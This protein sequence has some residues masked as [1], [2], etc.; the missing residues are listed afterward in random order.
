MKLLR[1]LATAFAISFVLGFTW[2]TSAGVPWQSGRRDADSTLS[3]E[4]GTKSTSLGGV[5]ATADPRPVPI[6]GRIPTTEDPLRVVMAGDSVMAGLSPPVKSAFEAGTAGN[7]RFVLTP[8]I[9]R[10]A[11][12][13]FTWE[14]QLAEFDPE[15]VVMFVGTWESHEV[16][17]GSGQ[18]VTLGDPRW[19][20]S[21]EEQVLDPWVRLITSQGARVLWIG[22]PA[23]A[24]P[25]ANLVFAGLNSVFSALPA[26]FPTVAYLDASTVLAGPEARFSPVIPDSSGRLVRTRQ[27]DGLH[28][29]ADGARVL[30]AEVI[31]RIA[32]D[33]S[34]PV[35]TGWDV[36]GAQWRTDSVLYPPES[37]PDVPAVA[38]FPAV[39]PVP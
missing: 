18:A 21:Y 11:T 9:I 19:R 31:A 34:V 24:N 15:V 37:C 28:L 39:A 32:A 26:R 6:G 8:S 25:E 36:P 1:I 35:G 3:A 12:V 4:S 14:Q 30:G 7:V 16:E 22:S 20:Q 17:I 33:W 13:R 5:A 23:A 2:G 27:V 29:C 38:P 10:D